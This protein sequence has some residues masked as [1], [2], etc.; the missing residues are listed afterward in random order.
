MKL[1]EL[2]DEY[3]RLFDLACDQSEPDGRIAPEF[4]QA[5][6]AI[7]GDI[8]AKL[9]GCWRV[10]RSIAAERDAYK[11]EAERLLSR[12]KSADAHFERLKAYVKEAMTSLG[13][14]KWEHGVA[15]FRI[16][17]NSQPTVIIDD[18][19]LLPAEAFVQP[20]PQIDKRFILEA[21]KA[22]K[23][24]PGAYCEVGSHLRVL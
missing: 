7:Q 24:V 3:L 21:I 17:R 13:M 2:R 9:D 1:Y 11:A 22:G 6:D 10:M 14:E 18:E 19:S 20:P 5:L 12:A 15:K 16:Q 4:V 23:D 8:D